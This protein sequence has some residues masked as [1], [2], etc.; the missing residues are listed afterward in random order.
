MRQLQLISSETIVEANKKLKNGVKPEEEKYLRSLIHQFYEIYDSI[1]KRISGRNFEGFFERVKDETRKQLVAT[2]K[3]LKG[4]P[5]TVEALGEMI[6]NGEH[7][8]LEYRP[9][10][11]RNKNYPNQ[12][13]KSTT[14]FTD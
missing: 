14:V 2:N 10:K 7:P 8:A 5:I 13:R 11:E 1:V 9:P 4:Y 3:Y 6:K 12:G